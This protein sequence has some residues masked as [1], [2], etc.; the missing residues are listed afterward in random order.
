MVAA[1]PRDG[2]CGGLGRRKPGG[3]GE[4]YGD[5][6]PGTY[7]QLAPFERAPRAPTGRLALRRLPQH[8]REP[9]YERSDKWPEQKL[10]QDVTNQELLRRGVNS[11]GASEDGG[12]QKRGMTD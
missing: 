3:P 10:G 11:A 7:W 6:V 9:C 1:G 2:G 5:G 12:Q 4:S 8:E